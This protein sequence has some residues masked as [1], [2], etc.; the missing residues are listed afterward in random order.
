MN[1]IMY[2]FRSR[3]QGKQNINDVT[4][5]LGTS[6]FCLG[7]RIL[8]RVI[9][10]AIF[11]LESSMNLYNAMFPV[12]SMKELRYSQREASLVIY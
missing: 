8:R 1:K 2:T 6:Y 11:L 7:E 5:R 9:K 3:E 12:S 10:R 4:T